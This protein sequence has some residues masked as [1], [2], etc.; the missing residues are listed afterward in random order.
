MNRT[1]DK[2]G[3]TG[4]WVAALSCPACFPA[5]GSLVS[6]LGLGFLSAFEGFAI[7]VLLHMFAS[8]VLLINL[9]AWYQHQNHL[10]GGL[11][12]LSPILILLVL[13]PL[14]EYSWSTY[15]FYGAISLMLTVSILDLV[16]PVRN[17]CEI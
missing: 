8:I 15:M 4:V 3:T 14:W 5:L 1:L 2:I 12:V 11:S 17:L 9:Y 10:R 7:N 16:K 13:Y 6:L